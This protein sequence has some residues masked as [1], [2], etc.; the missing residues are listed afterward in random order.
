MQKDEPPEKR[1]RK[2]NPQS[3]KSGAEQKRGGKL[4]KDE[5]PEKRRR[6]NNHVLSVFVLF[7]KVQ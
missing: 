2:C 4:Q 3:P 6:R 7:D 1:R 5:P